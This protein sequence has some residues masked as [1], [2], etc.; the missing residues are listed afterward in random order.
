MRDSGVKSNRYEEYCLLT[1][2]RQSGSERQLQLIEL[3]TPE[4]ARTHQQTIKSVF[5]FFH[6]QLSCLRV[7]SFNYS[8]LMNVLSPRTAGVGGEGGVFWRV[9]G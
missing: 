1:P 7:I 5:I 6:H 4:E 8:T 2:Q 3:G 9:P